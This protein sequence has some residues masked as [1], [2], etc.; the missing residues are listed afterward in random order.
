MKKQGIDKLV[1][2]L[3]DS[4]Y[5]AFFDDEG[6]LKAAELLNKIHEENATTKDLDS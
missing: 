2:M 1:C 5:K 4:I 6:P 3:R